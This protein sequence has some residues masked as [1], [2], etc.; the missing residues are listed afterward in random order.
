MSPSMT[1]RA[2]ASC[3]CAPTR[4]SRPWTSWA[5]V[6]H[7][8]SSPASQL[9]R[10][11]T[12]NGS[13][14]YRPL[15]QG[16]VQGLGHQAHLH[17]ALARDQRQ[18]ERFIQTCLREWAYGRVWNNSA[19]APLG[20]RP[21]PPTTP[22]DRIRC[23]PPASSKWEEPVATSSARCTWPCAWAR[24]RRPHHPPRLHTG[25]RRDR[26]ADRRCSTA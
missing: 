11:L 2:L 5:T 12:D 26:F 22:A 4:K 18:A 6:A 9:K 23:G 10:L 8:F 25:W 19:S 1:T 15:V 20:C 13:A 3:R 7:C 17:P 24:A 21:F 16:N 14:R